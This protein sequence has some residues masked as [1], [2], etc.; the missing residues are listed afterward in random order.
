MRTI[1]P[2]ITCIFL[3]LLLLPTAH[4]SWALDRSELVGYTLVEVKT[5]RGEFEG[6]DFDKKIR[7]LDGTRLTCAEYGYTYAYMP[8]AAIYSRTVMYK[9]KRLTLVKMV[10][11]D[12]IYDMY[13]W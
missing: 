2:A 6:C 8:E 10:V 5:V 12:E 11:E 1:I 7:F 9:G 13:S 4:A 3:V